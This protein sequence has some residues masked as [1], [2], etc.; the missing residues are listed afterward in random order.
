MTAR[1]TFR[2]AMR[3]RLKTLQESAIKAS[4]H[5]LCPADV[6]AALLSLLDVLAV[7]V[8]EIETLKGGKNG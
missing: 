8:A 7:M 4:R 6:R 1:L 3:S 2:H 5:P